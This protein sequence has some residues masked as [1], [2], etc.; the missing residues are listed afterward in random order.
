MS[1]QSIV[2]EGDSISVTEGVYA[3]DG[4]FDGV[5]G[6]FAVYRTDTGYG[7]EEHTG[8][9]AMPAAFYAI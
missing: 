2:M 8:D 3:S 7:V 6:S 4:Y 5:P 1:F 9:P